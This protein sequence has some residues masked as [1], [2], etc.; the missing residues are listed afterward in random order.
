[1]SD[2]EIQDL[3]TSK[4]NFVV[5]MSEAKVIQ[6]KSKYKHFMLMT[7]HDEGEPSLLSQTLQIRDTKAIC[8]SKIRGRTAEEV[9]QYV[10]LCYAIGNLIRA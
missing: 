8:S 3:R 4:V 2:R 9:I 7:E 6:Y 1:M 5:Q 10:M